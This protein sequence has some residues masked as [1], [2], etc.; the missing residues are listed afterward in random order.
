MTQYP[1]SEGKVQYSDWCQNTL[2]LEEYGKTLVS[3]AT[4]KQSTQEDSRA[5]NFFSSQSACNTAHLTGS[6]ANEHVD[7]TGTT[8]DIVLQHIV[9]WQSLAASALGS[10]NTSLRFSPNA[11]P[12]ASAA[13]AWLMRDSYL[14]VG[15]SANQ[16]A[17]DAADAANGLSKPKKEGVC[18]SG[19]LIAFVTSFSGTTKPLGTPDSACDDRLF[20]PLVIQI[21]SRC[22]EKKSEADRFMRAM[23]STY[24][25]SGTLLNRESCVS[26]PFTH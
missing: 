20:W 14:N 11:V 9:S 10:F 15:V 6:S 8:Q 16:A 1:G 13:A 3:I 24:I 2:G 18:F 19:K 22:R 5:F 23:D 4:T 7:F 17:Q 12:T 26:L 21:N 25:I